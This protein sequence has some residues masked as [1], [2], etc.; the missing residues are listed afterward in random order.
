MRTIILLLILFSTAGT[1]KAQDQALRWPLDLKTRYLTSNFMEHRSGRF[2]AGLDLKTQSKS[3]FPVRAVTDGWISRIRLTSGGYGKTLY[4]KGNDGRTYVYAHLERL[5]DPLRELV[6]HAQQRRGRWDVALQFPA[7]RHPVRS[8]DVLALTGQ[9]GTGGPHLHFEVR[10]RT[11]RPVDPQA[12]GFAVPDTIAPVILRLRAHPASPESRIEGTRLAHAMGDGSSA[13]SADLGTLAVQ[14][15][16]A[17]S[18]QVVEM[19][20]IRGHRLE[21]WRLQVTLDDSLVFDS[22]NE[23]LAFSQND[24]ALLEWLDTGEGRERWLHRHAEN[25]LDGRSGG[26]WTSDPSAWGTGPHNVQFTATDRAGNQ[27]QVSWKVVA[28]GDPVGDWTPAPV[29]VTH[30][31]AREGVAWLDPFQAEWQGTVITLDTL[32]LKLGREI[33]ATVASFELTADER[34]SA[35]HSQGL[36]S[37]DWAVEISA[38]SW[39]RGGALELE[40]AWGD[41]LPVDSGLYVET[42]RGWRFQAPARRHKNVWKTA[43]PGQGRYALFRDAQAP[44]LGPGPD[45]G[46]VLRG[47]EAVTEEI[48]PP[49]WLIVPIRLEDRGSGIDAHSITASWDGQALIVEPDLPRRRV[50]VVC[51]DDAPAGNHVLELQASDRE[52]NTI[53]RRYQLVLQDD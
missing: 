13:L 23:R 47:F 16:V 4:L 30:E 21:P 32:A 2:H 10:D 45:E 17:F 46:L 52:G 39:P 53:E 37:L 40:P 34:S 43:L 33:P 8:G 22:R 35:L 29:R 28:A 42:R 12:H 20:D 36:E 19:S 14:G 25:D 44:Y 26:I 5:S 1:L 18:A 24:R 41:S 3:G 38:V 7:G 48:T 9:S 6:E 49:H 51:P 27:A 31:P 50:L 15:P 11:N